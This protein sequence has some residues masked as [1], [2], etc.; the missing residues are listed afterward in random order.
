MRAFKSAGR[1]FCVTLEHRP[2]SAQD[3]LESLRADYQLK[4]LALHD[5]LA[6]EYDRERS[7]TN[8]SMIAHSYAERT[9]VHPEYREQVRAAL[10]RIVAGS[11]GRVQAVI[12]HYRRRAHENGWASG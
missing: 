4:R 8:Q 10:E 11:G 1:I 7:P 12:D 3:R 6:G 9:G 2:P 5:D